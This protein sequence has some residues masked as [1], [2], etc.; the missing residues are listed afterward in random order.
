MIHSSV[1]DRANDKTAVHLI[2]KS[3]KGSYVFDTHPQHFLV[4]SVF[5]EKHSFNSGFIALLPF[6]KMEGGLYQIGFCYGGILRFE[7]KLILKNGSRFS[8]ISPS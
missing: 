8:M 2:L 4:G 7:D 6:E 5:F 3:K 1:T